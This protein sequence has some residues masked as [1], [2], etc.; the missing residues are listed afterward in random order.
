MAATAS[1]MELDHPKRPPGSLVPAQAL[2]QILLAEVGD[3]HRRTR[4]I[5]DL[6]TN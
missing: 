1:W 3:V 2:M 4:E 5:E 6:R